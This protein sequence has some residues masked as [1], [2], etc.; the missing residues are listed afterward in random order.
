M[1]NSQST[2]WIEELF[3]THED[4][5]RPNWD[6]IAEHIKNSFDEHWFNEQWSLVVDVWLANIIEALGDG[7]WLGESHNFLIV[8][9]DS[10][11]SVNAL[12]RYLEDKLINILTSLTDIASD[13]GY[14]KHVV[15]VFD[16]K[17]QYYSYISYFYPEEGEFSGSAGIYLNRG[18]GHFALTSTSID[19]NE[20]VV[21]HELTHACLDHLPLPLWLN[22]GI[23]QIMEDK[24]SR[25]GRFVADSEIMDQHRKFWGNEE[26]QQFWSGRSFYRPDEGNELSYHLARLVVGA[27]SHNYDAFKEFVISANYHDGGEAAAQEVFGGSLGS[28]MEQFL[29]PGTWAPTPGNWSDTDGDTMLL[30]L[31]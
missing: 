2:D 8:S 28:V 24:I 13:E 5:P 15:I 23:T 26:I 29:G 21:A 19:M 30:S 1:R 14:G 6:A 25:S 17:D 10:E 3:E 18:Y 9:S 22:E 31:C 4:F 16:S 11:Q 20:I 12:A 7:Y 27:I